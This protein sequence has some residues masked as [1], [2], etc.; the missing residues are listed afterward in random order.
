MGDQ[1]LYLVTL[2]TGR[3]DDYFQEVLWTTT[4]VTKAEKYVDRFNSIVKNNTLRVTERIKQ[5]RENGGYYSEEYIEGFWESYLYYD[6]PMMKINTIKL[7]TSKNPKNREIILLDDSTVESLLSGENSEFL[8]IDCKV[9]Y[10][11]LEKGYED[12]SVIVKRL[13]DNKF[14]KFEYSCN[15]YYSYDYGTTLTEVFSTQI[16]KTIYE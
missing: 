4:D 8:Y 6:Y 13:S 3:Y 16:I 14:F 5:A 15:Y 7:K 9:T 1:I 11:D 2:C 10:Y 12:R